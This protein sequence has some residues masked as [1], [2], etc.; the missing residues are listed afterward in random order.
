MCLVKPDVK[1]LTLVSWERNF[2]AARSGYLKDTSQLQRDPNPPSLFV[3]RS[4]Y[5]L[6][7]IQYFFLVVNRGLNAVGI[8]QQTPLVRVCVTLV[9]LKDLSD[10]LADCNCW[11]KLL[12][13]PG[14]YSSLPVLVPLSPTCQETGCSVCRSSVSRWASHRIRALTL[15]SPSVVHCLNIEHWQ[16]NLLTCSWNP[17]EPQD[18]HKHTS[19]KT[20]THA[21]TVLEMVYRKHKLTHL[22]W[23]SRRE[24]LSSSHVVRYDCNII[25]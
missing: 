2:E 17:Q 8:L 23:G 16:C 12:D 4:N 25:I 9:W 3:S 20:R 22:S 21:S 11:P 1:T 7:R 5:F 13:P 18:R 19:Q 6:L 14:N 10:Q 15:Q 24:S